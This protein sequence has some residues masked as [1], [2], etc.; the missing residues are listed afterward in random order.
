MFT[1]PIL[2]GNGAYSGTLLDD[3][4]SWWT[5]NEASGNR[6]DS[7]GSNTLV[8]NDTVTSATG[9]VDTAAEF[10]IANT[11]WLAAPDSPHGLQGGA[12]DFTVACWL[13]PTDLA[14]VLQYAV[15]TAG[16]V[17]GTM[18]WL[19]QINTANDLLFSWYSS[20]FRSVT[21]SHTVIE[22]DWIFVV[23]WHVDTDPS[24]GSANIQVNNGTVDTH[25]ESSYFACADLSIPFY[26]GRWGHSSGRYYSGLIDEVAFW[27]RVLTA[28]ERTELY[29][30]GAGMTYPG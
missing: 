23:A 7:H 19:V 26:L 16:S 21:S 2:G 4:V 18:N 28:D 9:K 25:V 12:R 27:P 22:N 30:G 1:Y 29:N 24:F 20:G 5:L 8:D 3:L 14:G 17:T 11:E 13:K 6:A 15:G 10:V